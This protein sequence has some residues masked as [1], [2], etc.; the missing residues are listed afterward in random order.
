MEMNFETQVAPKDFAG[1]FEMISHLQADC[2]RRHGVEFD[3]RNMT[4]CQQSSDPDICWFIAPMPEVAAVESLSAGYYLESKAHHDV[5]KGQYGGTIK[6][7]DVG[8]AM[9]AIIRDRNGDFIDSPG[10]VN[11][12]GKPPGRSVGITVDVEGLFPLRNKEVIKKSL[13]DAIER[14][15]NDTSIWEK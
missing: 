6:T 14:A 4:I 7:M 5:K 3:V 10:R 12:K 2:V 1:F 13:N 15:L 11:T 8:D 9:E